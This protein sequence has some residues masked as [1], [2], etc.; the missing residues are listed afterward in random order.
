MRCDWQA[1]IDRTV[2]DEPL[3]K[4]YVWEP[5]VGGSSNSIFLGHAKQN[6]DSDTWIDEQS[7]SVNYAVK[8]VVLRINAPAKDTPGVSR[9]REATILDWIKPYNWAPQIIRNEPKQGWC[10]MHYYEDA[11]N[12]ERASS[13]SLP[14]Q[15][16]SILLNAVNEL[17]AI[18]IDSYRNLSKNPIDKEAAK[19]SV[20]SNKDDLTTNYETL[21]N[22]AYL[23]IAETKKD[24]Q[25]LAW[26]QLI[27][28]DLAALPKLPQCLVHH[29]LHLGNLTVSVCPENTDADHFL[30]ILDWE[31]A[32]IGSPW[33]DASC[34]SRYLSIPAN[35]I[36][37]LTHFKTLDK[38]TFENALK[39]S[40]E[41]TETLQKLW[42]RT[43][44]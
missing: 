33:F 42:Y 8:T 21:L 31:Y 16:H 10:L 25:A 38:T 29:D 4:A 23:S 24:T 37:K 3:K 9:K 44:E 5:F 26:I 32:S 17:H 27:K 35:E 1:L 39:R 36:H 7:E 20:L 11:I 43:R 22:T 41:M 2:Q 6:C 15:L 34:L 14:A 18:D 12:T 28:S 13:D 40:N 19:H 30:T